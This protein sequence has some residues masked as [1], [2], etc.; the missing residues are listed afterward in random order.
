MVAAQAASSHVPD[1]D[2][3]CRGKGDQVKRGA[4]AMEEQQ[5][6]QAVQL[7]TPVFEQSPACFH[8][9]GGISVAALLADAYAAQDKGGKALETLVTGYQQL[10]SQGRF[11]V[12]LADR[13]VR[14]AFERHATQH[15]GIAMRAYLQLL[16]AAG[17]PLLPGEEAAVEY[18]LN[19]LALVIPEDVRRRA[20]LTKAREATEDRSEGWRLEPG[21]GAVLA[22]W[23]RSQDVLPATRENERLEEH[24]ERV[25][26]AERHYAKSGRIDERGRTYIRLGKPTQAT[27]IEFNDRRFL[28]EFWTYKHIDQSAQYLFVRDRQDY[29]KEGEV[30]DLIPREWQLGHSSFGRGRKKAVQFLE[31]LEYVLRGLATYDADYGMRYG[32]VS[33][34]MMSTVRSGVSDPVNGAPSQFASSMIAEN[35]NEDAKNKASRELYLPPAYTSVGDEYAPLPVQVRYAR[36]LD[37]AKTHVEVYWSMPVSGLEWSAEMVKDLNL[38]EES[39]GLHAIVTTVA[40]ET[41][42]HVVESVHYGQEVVRTQEQTNGFLSPITVPITSGAPLFHV[43]MQWDA[44]TIEVGQKRGKARLGKLIKRKSLRLDSLQALDG[45]GRSLVMSDLKPLTNPSGDMQSLPSDST[46]APYPFQRVASD[47]PLALYFEVYNLTYDENDQTR[48]QIEYEVKRR[49]EKGGVARLWGGE[50]EQRTASST[51]NTGG[52][53]TSQEYIY[54]DLADYESKDGDLLVTVRVRDLVTGQTTEREIEF[55]TFEE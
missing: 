47:V 2:P 43:A 3:L 37:G 1:D 18:H 34:Y 55:R 10:E 52:Q 33:D 5:Y 35:E 53:R 4:L 12:H 46:W 32:E 19:R 14:T 11:G 41:P 40:K 21:G 44:Y 15:F 48:Y 9:D 16:A 42:D 50:R 49:T 45:S 17:T 51:E 23:W 8:V 36:F 20:G 39:S 26:Y 6:A 22:A 54:L 25:A 38:P 28:N 31:R 27:S 7:L 29:Y 13:L 24:L 30:L